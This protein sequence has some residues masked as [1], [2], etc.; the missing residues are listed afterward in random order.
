[1]NL[2][3]NQKITVAGVVALLTLI[4]GFL[5]AFGQW[6]AVPEFRRFFHLDKRA[7]VRPGP[8]VTPTPKEITPPKEVTPPKEIRKVFGTLIANREILRKQHQVD[9]LPDAASD[10]TLAEMPDHTLGFFDCGDLR[11]SHFESMMDK[12]ISNV[13]RESDF[14]MHKLSSQ[15]FY[16]I[17][18]VGAETQE[19]L[20][21]GLVSGDKL[22]IYTLPW[23]EAH[24]LVSLRLDD[25]NCQ[26]TRQI[27]LPRKDRIHYTHAVDCQIK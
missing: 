3:R 4:F 27:T 5:G 8:D 20:R 24:K 17:A 2:S 18:A 6:M 15:E 13:G 11:P 10:K 26:R 16:L 25:L 19:R 12:R 21:E 9:W 1:M 23:D 22:T 7:E 14:E